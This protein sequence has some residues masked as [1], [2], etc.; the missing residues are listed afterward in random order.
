MSLKTTQVKKRCQPCN[1]SPQLPARASE[2]QKIIH[3]SDI[4]YLMRIQTPVKIV[5]MM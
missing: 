2:K 3:V 4:K 5:N 1:I